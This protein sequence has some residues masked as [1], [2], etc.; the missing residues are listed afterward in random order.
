M[1][2]CNFNKSLFF[3]FIRDFLSTHTMRL[4]H[5]CYRRHIIVWKVLF[6]SKVSRHTASFKFTFFRVSIFQNSWTKRLILMRRMKCFIELISFRLWHAWN[7][8]IFG[9]MILNHFQ[10]RAIMKQE[11]YDYYESL[12]EYFLIFRKLASS[13]LRH[14]LLTRC[15]T[16]IRKVFQLINC[17]LQSVYKFHAPFH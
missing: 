4:D 14:S 10:Q 13:F 5:P 17:I 16:I 11:M 8:I 9:G 7:I 2:V 12:K 6:K 1:H 15:A 3:S